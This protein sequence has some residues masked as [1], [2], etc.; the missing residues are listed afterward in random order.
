M[1]IITLCHK[2]VSVNG[3]IFSAKYFP[4]CHLYV[5]FHLFGKYPKLCE[6]N[7]MVELK[8]K[9]GTSLVRFIKKQKIRCKNGL[10]WC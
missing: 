9:I 4:L 5:N 7:K 1:L 2:A 8:A 6:V 3:E 10:A